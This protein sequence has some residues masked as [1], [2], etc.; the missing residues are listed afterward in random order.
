MTPEGRAPGPCVCTVA[1][2]F[3]SAKHQHRSVRRAVYTG[4]GDT[5][6]YQEGKDVPT[7]CHREHLPSRPGQIQPHLPE[8]RPAVPHLNTAVLIEQTQPAAY[9]S[10]VSRDISPPPQGLWL[11][12]LL[13]QIGS[14]GGMWS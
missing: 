1:Q 6:R 3:L 14:D 10:A 11:K 2:R 13:K 4:R 12:R 7:A 8:D 5:V 9:I